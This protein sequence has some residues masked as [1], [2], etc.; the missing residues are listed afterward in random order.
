MPKNTTLSADKRDLTGRKV[1]KLRAQGKMPANIFGNKVKSQAITIDLLEFKKTYSQ[2]G[3]TSLV[4]I[5]LKGETKTRPSLIAN[6]QIH[7]VTDDPLHADF[8][9]VDLTQKVTA[10]VPVDVV[11]E[12]EAV[13]NKGAVLITLHN[14]LEVEALPTDLPDKFEVDISSLKDF[15]DSVLVKDL[16]VDAKVEIKLD[17]EEAIV[18][19]QE[20]KEEEIAPEPTPAA[21]GEEGEE[22]EEAK[23][24]EEPKE[25]EETKEGE[26]PK[27]AAEA[28]PEAKSDAKPDPD[29]K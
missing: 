11:G 16:K 12:S 7:P 27:D 5:K 23:D 20:P 9:Q 21:E 28:K 6:V 18:M 14:E 10:N 15:N 29:K 13:K 3:E 1:K 8:H 2:A 17:K 4:D 26:K 19:A 25:G 22:G 24:G